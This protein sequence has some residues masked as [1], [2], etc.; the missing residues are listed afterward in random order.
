MLAPAWVCTSTTCPRL[1]NSCTLAGTMP[2]RYSWFLISL[3]TPISMPISP[4]VVVM[5]SWGKSSE[6]SL[7][8]LEARTGWLGARVGAPRKRQIEPVAG[9]LLRQGDGGRL[10][11]AG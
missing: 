6:P 8:R 1:V 3:G 7:V 2:T 11:R 5:E 4:V 10:W 9:Q